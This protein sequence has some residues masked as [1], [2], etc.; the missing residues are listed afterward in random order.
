MADFYE[1]LGVSRDASD[2]EIKKAYRRLA[3][4]H[5]PDRNPDDKGAEEKFKEAANA[6]QV[7]SDPDMR[8][9]YDRFG[10]AGLSGAA[11]QSYGF[12]GVEDIFSTFGDLFGDFFGQR[13][14]RQ[15][16][17]ADLRMDL[18]LIFSEAVWGTTKEVEVPRRIPCETC[19]GSGAKPGTRPETCSQCGGK[20]QVVHS[21]GFFM[22]QTACPACRGEGSRIKE[23]CPDCRGQGV[24]EQ[25]TKLTVN[26]PAGVDNGQTLR[27][28]GKGESLRDGGQA[29]HL[30][31]VLHVEPDERFHREEEH[32]LTVASI[33]YVQAAL[34]AE[35]DVPTLDDECQGTAKVE[36][37]AGAQPGDVIVRRGEGITRVN[38]RGRGDHHVQLKVVIPT[39]LSQREQ[40]LLREI[41]DEIGEDVRE[42]KKGLFERIKER[43]D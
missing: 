25:R 30:Y 5:H 26:V 1:L 6:Y 8:A 35:I 28:A 18:R 37:K 36:V 12:S 39:K 20:G 29:G 27:L 24:Q 43:L 40:D 38:G 9:R 10:E 19:E 34:G 13:Q 16:R 32:V 31:V 22:I 23:H 33:S 7:L 15:Q 4:Q 41:A 14:Q 17:G 3:M 21:Q 2:G 42:P 11:S